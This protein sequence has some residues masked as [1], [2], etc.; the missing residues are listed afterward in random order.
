MLSGYGFRT[1][2]SLLHELVD[3]Y[4]IRALM[5]RKGTQYTIAGVVSHAV[6][7]PPF[8]FS[9]TLFMPPSLAQ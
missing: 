1:V 9:L 5:A 3:S 6:I 2:L 4:R 8:S 7:I